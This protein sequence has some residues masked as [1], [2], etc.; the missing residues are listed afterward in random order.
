MDQTQ[1]PTLKVTHVPVAVQADFIQQQAR[2]VP[3]QAL[4]ECIWNGLDSDAHLVEVELIRGALGL[5]RIIVRDDGE[6]MT[7]EDA[8][9]LFSKLGDSWKRRRGRTTSGRELHGSEGRGRYKVTV[10]GRVADW[11]VTY[12]ADGGFRRFTITVI[13]DDLKRVRLTEDVPVEA[14]HTGVEL[15]VSELEADF[16]SLQSDD[17]PQ[18]LAEIF[19]TYLR[20]YSDVTISLQ[21]VK[22]DPAVIMAGPPAEMNLSDINDDGR[23]YPARLE[24]VEWTRKTK[25]ILYLCDARGFPMLAVD[26]RWHV[27]DRFFSAY[28]RSALVRDMSDR[29][30]IGVGEMN[31]NL[32]AAVEEA[33]QRI[34]EHFRARS[35]QE[36]QSVV[37]A[38]KAEK[39]YPYE[40]APA[41]PVESVAREVFDIMATT[42]A[43]YLPEFGAASTKL[44]AFQLRMMRTAIE[45]GS[46]ELQLVMK[47]VLNLPS[48]QLEELAQLI[49]ES[50][51]PAIISASKEIANR[52]K[53]L[54]GLQALI[55]DRSMGSTLKERTQLHRFLADNTWVFGEEHHLMVDDRSLDECLRQHTQAKNMQVAKGAVRH[56]SKARGIVDLMFGKQRSTHR[57]DELEH[58]V[59]ELKAPSVRIGRDEISQVEGYVSAIT[60][61]HRFDKTTTRWI[62]WALSREVD[63][64][65]MRIRQVPHAAEGV[66]VKQD[67]LLVLVKTWAQVIAE[68]RARMKFF[69]NS[70]QLTVTKADALRHLKEGYATILKDTPV[71]A[72]IQDAIEAEEEGAQVA[73]GA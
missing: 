32:A 9:D 33:R 26:T 61:D 36:A 19:A 35:A 38:W 63:H 73:M 72:A 6:G 28:L 53:F 25:R 46:D 20:S 2:T 24:I 55:F 67:N 70:L 64:E 8:P 7:R 10:L 43:R 56:P 66:I 68:N 11:R 41:T 4:A 45:N 57:A 71:E 21:G 54:T 15:T 51:L 22:I 14:A 30:E 5:E 27:G 12:K 49:Q 29:N 42:A 58:L 34:K 59:V 60:A 44:R 17:A 23:T 62:F 3:L 37:E 52:L 40:D 50:S 16:R 18:E 13:Q 69:Q 1:V 47:E 31:P 39:A 48:R 65:A